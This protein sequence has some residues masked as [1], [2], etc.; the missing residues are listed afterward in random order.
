MSFCLSFHQAVLGPTGAHWLD[1]ALDL[2]SQD[3]IQEHAVDG[4]LLSCKQLVRGLCASGTVSTRALRCR[5]MVAVVVAC[6][7][8]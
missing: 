7:V 8:L 2:S 6:L 4:S 5:H 3:S 1:D